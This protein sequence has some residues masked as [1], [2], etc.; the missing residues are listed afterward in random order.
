MDNEPTLRFI[1]FYHS[2]ALEILRTPTIYGKVDKLLDENEIDSSDTLLVFTILLGYIE[3]SD[4]T[5]FC[6]ALEQ[7]LRTKLKVSD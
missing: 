4:I 1:N 6:L 2:V 7:R 5:S 3:E